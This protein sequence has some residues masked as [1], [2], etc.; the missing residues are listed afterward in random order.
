M[1]LI[2]KNQY[3]AGMGKN[4]DS[5]HRPLF[6]M[7]IISCASFVFLLSSLLVKINK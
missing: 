2:S 6:T 7:K 1:H 5:W 3:V 4:I